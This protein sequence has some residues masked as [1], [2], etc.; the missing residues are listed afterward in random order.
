M[1]KVEQRKA[2]LRGSSKSSISESTAEDDGV[3]ASLVTIVCRF[4]RPVRMLILS[5]LSLLA[6]VAWSAMA[7]T[8]GASEAGFQPFT[9]PPKT[10]D[11]LN[12]TQYLGRWYQMYSSL[13]P[14]ST[15]ERNGS[16]VFADYAPSKKPGVA[17]QLTNSQR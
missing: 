11:S 15:F 5:L 9:V 6:V 1:S 2:K 8:D 17:F 14:N 7:S 13:V 10:V 16:C 12:T 4:D 3:E